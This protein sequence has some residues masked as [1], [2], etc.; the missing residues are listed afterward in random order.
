MVINV[1]TV[2]NCAENQ[3]KKFWLVKKRRPE[4]EGFLACCIVNVIKLFPRFFPQNKKNAGN[5]LRKSRRYAATRELE[6]KPLFSV[7]K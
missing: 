5:V 7:S 4:G 6:V 1:I 2:V 3:F